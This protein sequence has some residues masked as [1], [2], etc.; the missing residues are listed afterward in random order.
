MNMHYFRICI[1]SQNYSQECVI[2]IERV[3]IQ[4]VCQSFLSFFNIVENWRYNTMHAITFMH[5]T[6]LSRFLWFFFHFFFS[7]NNCLNF[8]W[9]NE[10]PVQLEQTAQKHQTETHRIFENVKNN[11]K[12]LNS[13]WN[14]NS[15]LFFR[16][17]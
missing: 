3:S 14:F 13:N 9:W 6:F 11:N 15:F 7:N 12:R 1:N 17:M 8:G 10:L 16:I 4:V 5:N 2:E